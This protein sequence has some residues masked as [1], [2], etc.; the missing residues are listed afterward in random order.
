MG[1]FDILSSVNWPDPSVSFPQLHFFVL[2]KQDV[3]SC[4]SKE[5]AVCL[6]MANYFH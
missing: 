4:R 3:A 6:V 1:L 5:R 2:S